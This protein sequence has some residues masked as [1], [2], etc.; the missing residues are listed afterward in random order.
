[1]KK[2]LLAFV[3][4]V[5]LTCAL[6]MTAMAAES[7]V[8]E[9]VE[10]S[11]D[12]YEA[13][14]L[15][16]D[17]VAAINN[18]T[19]STTGNDRIGQVS[20]KFI[21]EVRKT[22]GDMASKMNTEAPVILSVLRLNLAKTADNMHV[23]QVTGVTSADSIKVYLYD[24]GNNVW[25]VVSAFS[26]DDGKIQFKADPKYTFAIISYTGSLSREQLDKKYEAAKN[27]DSFIAYLHGGKEGGVPMQLNG[28]TFTAPQTGDAAMSYVLV[29]GIACFAL[30]VVSKKKLAALN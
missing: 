3:S 10:Y 27:N 18:Q 19:V 17:N 26:C 8:A 22:F 5:V 14:A 28:S 20:S 7:P 6:P 13:S 23:F 21:D 4:A 1:M 11:D 15:V 24:E 2:R 30:A 16:G 12:D 29:A 9:V 25:D